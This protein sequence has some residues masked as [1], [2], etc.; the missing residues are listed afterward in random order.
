MNSKSALFLDRDGVINERLPGD[1]VSCLH[2]F[3]FCIGS[4]EAIALLSP[5]FF[6]IVVV[7]NQAGIGKGLM[8]THQLHEIHQWMLEQV[9]AAGGRIDRIYFCP[10]RSEEGADCRKPAVG[11]GKKA[12]QD[13][14]E[15]RLEAAWVVGDSISDIEFGNRM[16]INTALVEGKEEEMAAQKTIRVDWKGPSLLAFA[17]YLTEN[18]PIKTRTPN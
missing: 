13:F 14:P 4:L 11:M 16:E 8:S 5:H 9:E 10:Y 3:R 2:D 6:P 12:L 7:T 17:K 15:I 1:Y 18:T